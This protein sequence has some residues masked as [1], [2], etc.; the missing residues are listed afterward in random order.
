MEFSR[1]KNLENL[2]KVE[3]WRIEELEQRL[4]QIK[5][6]QLNP[7]SMLHLY[8]FIVAIKYHN[9]MSVNFNDNLQ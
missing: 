3:F 6:Y 9:V 1:F 5:A 8:V 4:K 7:S 2:D